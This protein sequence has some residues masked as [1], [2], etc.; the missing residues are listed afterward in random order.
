MTNKCFPQQIV[1][2]NG[3]YLQ[4][5]FLVCRCRV[6]DI[7]VPHES[8]A[9]RSESWELGVLLCPVVVSDLWWP[10]LCP[11]VSAGRTLLCVTPHIVSWS[12]RQDTFHLPRPEPP[13]SPPLC[14]LSALRSPPSR[15]PLSPRS[16]LAATHTDA[17][18]RAALPK[19]VTPALTCSD[20]DLWA[21][22]GLYLTPLSRITG[23]A[24]LHLKPLAVL[25]SGRLPP[26]T[27][28]TH[29]RASHRFRHSQIK[30]SFKP[31]LGQ[32]KVQ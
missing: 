30:I 6:Y 4:D 25:A 12:Q 13:P 18:P 21:D 16:R 15:S 28:D 24:R 3:L 10:H 22:T 5:I 31:S 23:R 2:S 29:C 19:P 27:S 17:D 20:T 14:Q 11:R 1:C 8:V 26:L 32:T 7:F 9:L